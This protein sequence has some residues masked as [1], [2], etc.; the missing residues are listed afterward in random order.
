MSF[1]LPLAEMSRADKLRVMEALWADLSQQQE[2]FD[3]PP[4]HGEALRKA[5]EAVKSDHAQFTDWDEAKQ[6]VARQ[7]AELG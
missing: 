1:V 5:E 4:W 2:S 6:R 3:S 7:A